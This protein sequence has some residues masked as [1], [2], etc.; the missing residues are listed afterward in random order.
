MVRVKFRHFVINIVNLKVI[1]WAGGE[2]RGGGRI[3]YILIS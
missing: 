3:N 2:G 1:Q